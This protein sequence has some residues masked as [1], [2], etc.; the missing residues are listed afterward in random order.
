LARAAG[1]GFLSIETLSWR[2]DAALAARDIASLDDLVADLP[3]YRRPPAAALRAFW[4]WLTA[5]DE[6]ATPL[7]IPAAAELVVLGRSEDCDVALDDH[8]ISRHHV[9][10]RRTSEG[11]D[12]LDL[13]STNGTWLNGRRITNAIGRP[14][15][16][17]ALADRAFRLPPGRILRGP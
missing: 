8:A 10:L 14:G 16:V 17:L 15:D 1:D 2:L 9:R 3:W 13:G 11:W 4:H 6:P 12:I 5:P 7:V